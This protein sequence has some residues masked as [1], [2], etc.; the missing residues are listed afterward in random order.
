[1]YAPICCACSSVSTGFLRS[2]CAPCWAAGMRPVVTWNS[3]EA[4]PTPMRLGPLLSTPSA[5]CPWQEMQVLSYRPLP[6]CA[7]A[8]SVGVSC[9]DTLGLK[10]A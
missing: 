4:E 3:T 1:M 8:L 7:A 6:A 2:I 5:F 10:A 9:A